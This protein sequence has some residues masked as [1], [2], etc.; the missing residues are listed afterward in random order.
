M[1]LFK[2][3]RG[4]DGVNI[5]HDNAK[6]RTLGLFY[7]I[8]INYASIMSAEVMRVIVLMQTVGNSV[9]WFLLFAEFNKKFKTVAVRIRI[10]IC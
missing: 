7:D 6:A 5:E 3:R 8:V 1:V 10:M 4:S 2:W 9:A